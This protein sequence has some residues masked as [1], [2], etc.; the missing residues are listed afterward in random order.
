MSE[1]MLSD[2]LLAYP[3]IRAVTFRY[4]NVAGSD[5]SKELNSSLLSS[6]LKVAYGKKPYFSVYGND[7]DSPD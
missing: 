3:T 1:V 4:F 6:I 5:G 2:M 7:F